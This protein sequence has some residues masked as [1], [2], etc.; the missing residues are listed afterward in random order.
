MNVIFCFSLASSTGWHGTYDISMTLTGYKNNK[1]LNELLPRTRNQFCLI[2]VSCIEG[3]WSG[4]LGLARA[5]EREPIVG[6][7]ELY[8]H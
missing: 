2:D 8:P 5:R 3:V 6:V 1:I 7:W 4:S